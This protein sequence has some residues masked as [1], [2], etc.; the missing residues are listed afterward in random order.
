M[1]QFC[2]GHGGLVKNYRVRQ[3][4]RK[5]DKRDW[6]KRE[7]QGE[8]GGGGG[9]RERGRRRETERS[10]K[11]LLSSA[12]KPTRQGGTKHDQ[13]STTHSDMYKSCS[14]FKRDK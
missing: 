9:E 4:A 3:K 5:G 6:R 14:S 13:L 7:G 12:Y 1:G 11:F 8:K 10:L 2:C